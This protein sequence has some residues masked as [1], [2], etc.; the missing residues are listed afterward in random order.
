MA[1]VL[2]KKDGYIA[3]F[4]PDKI[5]VVL[6]EKAYDICVSFGKDSLNALAA[7]LAHEL[8]HYYEKHDWSRHFAMN[9]ENL[10]TARQL[11]RMGDGLKQETEADNLGGF[12]AFSVGYNTYGIMPE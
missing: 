2:N 1:L 5:Q 8:I 3:S 7:L 6:D 9:N 12:M 10:E 11:E 4:N